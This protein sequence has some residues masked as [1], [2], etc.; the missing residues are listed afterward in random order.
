MYDNGGIR[1]NKN[2][3][4][5]HSEE[6]REVYQSR[7]RCETFEWFIKEHLMFHECTIFSSLGGGKEAKK[8]W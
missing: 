6:L 5:N 4:K 2:E 8:G 3:S 7:F 1:Q